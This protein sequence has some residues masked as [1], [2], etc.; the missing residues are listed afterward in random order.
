MDI[1]KTLE[2]STVEFHLYAGSEFIWT[3]QGQIV[4][5]IKI[6]WFFPFIIFYSYYKSSHSNKYTKLFIFLSIIWREK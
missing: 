6:D 3:C 5:A 4:Y 2:S 1:V